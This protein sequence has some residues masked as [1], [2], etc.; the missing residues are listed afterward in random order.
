MRERER[1]VV[2]GLVALMLVLWIGFLVHRSPRFPGSLEGSLL[3]IAAAIV[4][5]VPLLYVLIKRVKPLRRR[6]TP[7]ISMRTLLSVHIYAGI[8]APILAIVHT[9][10]RFESPIGIALVALMLIV[11]L[12]GFVGR[13]LLRMVGEEAKERRSLRDALR[14]EYASLAEGIATSPV[15]SAFASALN[16]PIRRR[17]AG[18]LFEGQPLAS[19]PSLAVWRAVRVAEALADTEFAVSTQEMIQRWFKRW[20]TLHIALTFGLYLLLTLHVAVELDLGLRWL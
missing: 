11:V 16:G 1:F 5:A 18:W 12:S 2:G 15:E 9:G 20:L 4:M 6:V 17:L 13:H 14:R 7:R 10:H 3:G 19:G 8:I